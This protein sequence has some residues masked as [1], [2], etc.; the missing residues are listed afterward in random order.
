MVSLGKKKKKIRRS[1]HLD[2][3]SSTSTISQS[4]TELPPSGRCFLSGCPSSRLCFFMWS[5]RLPQDPECVTQIST[6]WADD[7]ELLSP[8]SSSHPVSFPIYSI[9][10]MFSSCPETLLT[11]KLQPA[12]RC[13]MISFL[14][15]LPN[16]TAILLALSKGS[17]YWIFRVGFHTQRLPR[18][19]SSFSVR[20]HPPTLPPLCLSLRLPSQCRCSRSRLM[21]AP[22]SQQLALVPVSAPVC[23]P[24]RDKNRHKQIPS[25]FCHF[26]IQKA[27]AISHLS[28]RQM[29]FTF[30]FSQG[31]PC[32]PTYPFL[33]TKVYIFLGLDSS[34]S[35]CWLVPML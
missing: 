22:A 21:L 18:V 3:S 8:S 5:A 25:L 29:E 13:F 32:C 23:F 11:P 1:K 9:L 4:R 2:S 12:T 31:F 16:S 35:L 27:A 20:F 28:L 14:P 15:P 7:S 19:T 30:L 24:D 34:T 33:P 17:C 10:S 6:S 26:P